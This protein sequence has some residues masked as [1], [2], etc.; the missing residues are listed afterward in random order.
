MKV[1][2]S[3]DSNVMV[4]GDDNK[5]SLLQSDRILSTIHRCPLRCRETVFYYPFVRTYVHLCKV[6]MFLSIIMLLS[7]MSG[8]VKENEGFI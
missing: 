2:Y 3:L 4:S 6:F 7:F 8:I 1:T 5:I